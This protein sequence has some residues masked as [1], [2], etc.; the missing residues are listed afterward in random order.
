MLPGHGTSTTT[1]NKLF[2]S[3]RKDVSP[4]T[5]HRWLYRL[6]PKNGGSSW[7]WSYDSLIYNYHHHKNCEFECR[8]WRSVLDRTLCDKVLQLLATDRWLSPGTLVSSTYETDRHDITEILLKVALN[9]I[10]QTNCEHIL[11]KHV[12]FYLQVNFISKQGWRH[13]RFCFPLFV[14]NED[15]FVCCIISQ[16]HKSNK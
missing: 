13:G 1:P 7:L 4:N 2:G 9:I 10:H 12:Y 3:C 11:Q 15:D 14:V 6:H 5:S 16:K 8:S